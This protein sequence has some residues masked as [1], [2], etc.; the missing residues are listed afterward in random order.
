MSIS[1]LNPPT[2]FVSMDAAPTGAPS[3]ESMK[4]FTDSAKDCTPKAALLTP[5]FVICV[6]LL[7]FAPPLEPPKFGMP[8]IC[9]LP[10]FGMPGMEGFLPPLL[11][12]LLL[13]KLGMPGG[14]AQCHLSRQGVGSACMYHLCI[15]SNTH[16][17]LLESPP[18]VERSPRVEIVQLL[19]K[20]T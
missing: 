13:P 1:T 14:H 11:P 16:R 4:L 18:E 9:P 3:F 2:R 12:K 8:G 6:Y 10:K 19:G 15:L 7:E 17:L 20:S 5:V